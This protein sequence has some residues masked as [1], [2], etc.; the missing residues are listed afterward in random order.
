M[1]KCPCGLAYI[2]KTSRPLKNIIS[3]HRCVIGNHDQKSPVSHHFKR[4]NHNV[5]C[6]SY[7]GIEHVQLAKREAGINT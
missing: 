5:S 2:G 6:L 4:M 1:L 3:E 7:I